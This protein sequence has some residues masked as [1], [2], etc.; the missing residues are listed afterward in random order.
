MNL[1][2][3]RVSNRKIWLDMKGRAA[4]KL[5]N[6]RQPILKNPIFKPYVGNLASTTIERELQH[7]FLLTAIS[8]RSILLKYGVCSTNRPPM[9]RR[10]LI[11]LR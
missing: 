5:L 7:L 2:P 3:R 9:T 6:L 8:H 1:A 10:S 4:G 11:A